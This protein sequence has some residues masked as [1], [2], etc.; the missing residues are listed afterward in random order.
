MKKIFLVVLLLIMIF[1]LAAE[2]KS[3]RKAM[4]LSAVLP[5]MGEMYTTNYNKAATFLAVEAATWFMYFRLQSERQWALNSYKDFAFSITE[6]SKNSADW[7]YQL[8][9]DYPDSDT[10]NAD[11]I[12]DARNY[13]LIYNNDPV[14]Y[15]EYLDANLVPEENAWDWEN[16]KNW[17]KFRDL[18]RD[19]Q[20][21]EI[22]MKF[23]F[24]AAIVNRF[25][26]VV[27]SAILTKKF[28]RDQKEIGSLQVYPDLA[29]M[30]LKLKYEIKF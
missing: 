28:N 13:Y 17:Y 7:Y 16:D 15:E 11:I 4:L 23:A 6:A 29:N 26:S 19:K 2:T 21:M 10:Y 1:Q 3:I 8:L 20:N 22:Y 5:G 18:R 30:G 9:Q 25:I 27:D 24:A 14:G 12:R